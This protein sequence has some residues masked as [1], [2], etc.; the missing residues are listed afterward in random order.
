M[1]KVLKVLKWLLVTVLCLILALNVYIIIQSKSKPNSVPSVFGYKPFIVLSGSMKP[2][3][4]VGDLILVKKVDTNKLKVGDVIAFRD[5]ENYVTTHRIKKIIKG[6]KEPCFVTQGDNNNTEDAEKACSK[7]VEGK[8]VKRIARIGN[9][10]LFIQ[11]PLGFTIM[12]L[13]IFIVCVVIYIVQDKKA[14]KK[15]QLAN[16]EEMKAFEEFRKAQ[17]AKKNEELTSSNIEEQ[18]SSDSTQL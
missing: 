13:V 1:K 10:L 14:N 8:Y 5:S 18:D 2:N 9:A 17:E 7:S 12:M 3:I 4:M 15:L 6:D 16:A 11:E